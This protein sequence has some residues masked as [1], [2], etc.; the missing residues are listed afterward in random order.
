MLHEPAENCSA[1]RLFRTQPVLRWTLDRLARSQRLGT[2]AVICWEDQLEAV[3]PVAADE[4]AYVLAKGPRIALPEIEAIAAAQR[5]AVGWRGGLL[6]T[7]DFDLGFYAPYVL[8]VV[9]ELG[10]DAVLLVDPSSG[11]IDP[12]LIDGMI[13]HASAHA[14]LELTFSPAAA[15]LGGALLRPSLVRK[16]AEAKGHPGKLL[17][18]LPDP[19]SREPLAGDGCAPTPRSAA[20]TLHRFKLDSDR[21]IARVAGAMSTLNGHLISSGAED[22]V[23]K[24]HA[25]GATDV[26][27]RE[28]VVELNTKRATRPVFWP[29]SYQHIERG[30]LGVERAKRLFDEL[31][32]LDDTRITFGGV[33]DPLL[34][35]DLPAIVEAAQDAGLRAL[36]VETDLFGVDEEQVARLVDSG[37]DVVSAH[38]PALTSETYAVVMGVD[39]YRDVLENIRT[40][41]TRRQERGTSLPVLAPLFV[42][43]RQNLAEMG[44][45][46]DQWLRA[47]GSAVIS[48]PSNFAGQAED[49]SSA[50]LAPPR[51]RSC[52]RLASRITVLCSG[53][54]VSCE[55]DVLGRQVMGHLDADSIKTIWQKR[56]GALRAD[57]GKSQWSKHALCGACTDWHRP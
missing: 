49:V 6:S 31:A 51:R 53:A 40:F 12:E 48:G 5:W 54:V 50:D 11:L 1:N 19:L 27:P 17:H 18:Y 35:P 4:R 29:G 7:C 39:G 22:L 42:K 32:E 16:L 38:L 10:S 41:V 46:Y 8:E 33:G 55:Q 26:L 13:E 56:F 20:R 2:I 24:S 43:C 34:S 3:Y 21:Q 57:H 25:Y 36:H 37:V 52:A 30:E 45:W 15:G 47:V 28:V 14:D 44:G 9:H 23:A